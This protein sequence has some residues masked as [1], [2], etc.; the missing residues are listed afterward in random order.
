MPRDKKLKKHCLPLSEA[1]QLVTKLLEDILEDVKSA[2][3]KAQ[4]ILLP[5]LFRSYHILSPLHYSQFTRVRFSVLCAS[6][7]LT[8]FGEAWRETTDFGALSACT[9]RPVSSPQTWLVQAKG[10]NIQ[11]RKANWDLKRDVG[12]K[13]E[14][15]KKRTERAILELV[16]K[17]L[18]RC[19]AAR[20]QDPQK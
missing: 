10:L 19:L 12:K 5:S 18:S 16:R 13:L 14:K 20:G 9:S 15:L 6:S 2:D 17:C 11:P 4:V 1:P 7:S 3:Q 8:Q